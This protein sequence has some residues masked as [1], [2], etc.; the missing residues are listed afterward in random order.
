MTLRTSS[1]HKRQRWVGL[2]FAVVALSALAISS[3]IAHS[4][5]NAIPSNFFTVT[6]QQ[7]VNDVNS[8]QVDLTQFGRDD[9]NQSKYKLF[10]SW[11]SISS[12]TGTGQTGDACALFDTGTDGKIDKAVCARVANVNADPNNV[13]LVPEDGTHPVFLFD[14]SNQKNDRCTQTEILFQV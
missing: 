6:D 13:Q 11:D 5:I 9:S 4:G 8:D 1:P 10:W 2:I 12:W 3:S 14:C 7:G